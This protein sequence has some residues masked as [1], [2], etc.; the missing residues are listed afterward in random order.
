MCLLFSVSA[1]AKTI[2]LECDG[3]SV[4]CGKFEKSNSCDTPKVLKSLL[5][6]D[7]KSVIDIDGGFIDF[8]NKCEE[9]GDTITCSA[10]SEIDNSA[11]S[12]LSK[13]S[14]TMTINRMTGK[15][16]LASDTDL[17]STSALYA[18]GQRGYLFKYDAQ[19]TPRANKRLF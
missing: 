14:R 10:T 2:L 5:S 12:S 3:K 19:C 4:L 6:F 15:L 11:I 1:H 16:S 8:K 18:K 9:V 13:N 17:N 7:G